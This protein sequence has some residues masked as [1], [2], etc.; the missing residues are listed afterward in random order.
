MCRSILIF[1]TAAC[2]FAAGYEVA[3]KVVEKKVDVAEQVEVRVRQTPGGPQIFVDGAAIPPHMFWGREIV[4]PQRVTGEWRT[5]CLPH[6]PAVTIEKAEVRFAY[7]PAAGTLEVR[8]FSFGS[9]SNLSW[10]IDR[11]STDTKLWKAVPVGRLERGVTYPLT[12]EARGE[13]IGW[14]RPGVEQLEHGPYRYNLVQV[15]P[16][17]ADAV[18]LVQQARLAL[19]AGVRIVTFY[20]PNCW[21]PDGEEN[22][23]PLDRIFRE[24][25]ALDPDVL[26]LPRVTLNAPKWWQNAHPDS[27][28]VMDNGAKP[29][30]ACVSSRDYR[31]DACAYAEKI[32]RHMM[33]KYPHNFAGIHP[34]GQ[35]SNEWFYM[36]AWRQLNGYD[37]QTLAAFRAWLAAKGDPDAAE[38]V[39]PECAVRRPAVRSTLFLDPVAEKRIVEFNRFQQ[40]EMS[41]FVAAV[42]K[43]C[44]KATEGKKLVMIFYGYVWEH[45]MFTLGPAAGG[46]YGL[47]RLIKNAGDSIDILSAP[48]SYRSERGWLGSTIQMSAIE[49][50]TRN[51]I[52]WVAEDD[53]V[54]HHDRGNWY[55]GRKH[56]ATSACTPGQTHDIL[57]RNLAVQAVRGTGSWWMDLNGW[58]WYYDPALWRQIGEFSAFDGE[59]LRRTKPHIPD[60]AAFVDE[61]S[62]MYL[63]PT[64][65]KGDE[66]KEHFSVWS[67]LFAGTWAPLARLGT[68]YGQYVLEDVLAKPIQAKLQILP[69]FY[70]DDAKA[71]ALAKMRTGAPDV[72]RVWCWAP[73]AI[74][75]M[76]LD[77]AQM[78]R[79]TGFAFKRVAGFGRAVRSTPTGRA[80]GLPDEWA[81]MWKRGIAPRFAVEPEPGDEVWATWEDGSAAVVV[82]P[83]GTGNEVFF[84]SVEMPR[85]FLAAL[86][87]RAGVFVSLE[88]PERATLWRADGALALQALE[89]GEQTLLFPA[90]TTVKDGLTGEVL[91]KGVTR[92]PIS[93][94]KGEVRAFSLVK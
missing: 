45:S 7:Q 44:R 74:S 23:E 78:K 56:R 13:G 83:H 46:H 55:E 34:T 64:V 51:G 9:A 68:S 19:A 66:A 65:Y 70:A 18:T 40:E 28:M 21:M 72:T 2:C 8:K 30:Y 31:R 63:R 24:L 33:E 3:P 71:S 27:C 22:W 94:R 82:R 16:D 17:D 73:A 59:M 75:P 1:C 54:T 48:I 6:T 14:V 60:V 38:A 25:I 80:A 53:T 10:R 76:G 35:N 12:F 20:T 86:V 41:D 29:G 67:A 91:G 50:L 49:T 32:C 5:F 69:V 39:V 88:H 43:T 42:A 77:L 85:E 81:N 62:M 57:R 37:P 52:L 79:V 36:N 87:K 26:I 4:A 15:P 58:N 84:G 92:L 11:T 89:D 47:M 61:E 93:L 90:P